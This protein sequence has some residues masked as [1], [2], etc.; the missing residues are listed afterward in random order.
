MPLTNLQGAQRSAKVEQEDVGAML[1]IPRCPASTPHAQDLLALPLHGRTSSSPTEIDRFPSGWRSPTAGPDHFGIH[2]LLS[3]FLRL[4]RGLGE[5]CCVLLLL[6]SPFSLVVFFPRY[7]VAQEEGAAG[8]G[9]PFPPSL[10]Q[11]KQQ[12]S[13]HAYSRKKETEQRKA[14]WP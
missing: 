10:F 14:S 13:W 9:T 7:V 4:V 1:A 5:L 6:T 2:P 8:L 12:A 11:E 3:A